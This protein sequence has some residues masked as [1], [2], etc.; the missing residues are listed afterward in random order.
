VDVPST[1]IDVA[2]HKMPIP[3]D[4]EK[5]VIVHHVTS[6]DSLAGVSLKYG[7]SLG[8]LRRANRLWTSDSIHRRELLYIPVDQ[9]SRAN[10]YIP[11][12]ALMS[13]TPDEQDDLTSVLSSTSTSVSPISQGN[14]DSVPP[15][16]SVP[17]RR[18]PTK[19]LS[20]FPPSTTK[21]PQSD[22]KGQP[23]TNNPYLQL[24]SNTLGYSRY[25]SSSAN[26]SLTTILTALPIAAS[27]RDEILTRLSLDSVSSSLGDRSQVNSDEEAGHELGE[28]ASHK[29]PHVHENDENNA[30]NE[31]DGLSIPTPKASQGPSQLPSRK[32]DTVASS[33]SLPRSSH[34]R[35]HSS[36]SPP[37]FYVSHTN[38]AYVRTSQMEPSPAM[39]LPVFQNSTVGRSADKRTQANGGLVRTGSLTLGRK[40]PNSMGD[41]DLG[42]ILDSLKNDGSS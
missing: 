9:A 10:E 6:K 39:Q 37:R 36:T 41:G 27:T 29:R 30:A 13:F 11:E 7:I 5:E 18:I 26:N 3:S 23:Q 32:Q 20:Y 4:E 24:P 40:L 12:P 28:V 35:S 42:P 21:I 25:P 38:R 16:S 19:Q 8:D 17:I 15:S 33:S 14:S 31:V 2:T 1:D 34:T 22:L